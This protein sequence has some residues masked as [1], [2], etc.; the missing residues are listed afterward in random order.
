MYDMG[1]TIQ[2]SEIYICGIYKVY[3]YIYIY[4]YLNIYIYMH[5]YAIYTPYIS[6][7]PFSSFVI[8]AVGLT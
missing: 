4:I 6:Y 2:V 5:Q 8:L 1:L 7:I 3:I